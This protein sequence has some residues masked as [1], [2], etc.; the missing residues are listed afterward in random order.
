MASPPLP[1]CGE[2]EVVGAAHAL[3]C[4]DGRAVAVVLEGEAE[5]QQAGF[6][7]A[8]NGKPV[9]LMVTVPLPTVNVA[10]LAPVKA[11]ASLTSNVKAWVTLVAPLTLVKLTRACAAACRRRA[12]EHAAGRVE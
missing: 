4:A 10:R 11:G 6:D 3:A 9:V 5:R 12:A 7:S 1:L 8:A 2:I